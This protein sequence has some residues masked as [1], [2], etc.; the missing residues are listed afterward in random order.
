MLSG[1]IRP[2][3]NLPKYILSLVTKS[4]PTYLV[5]TGPRDYQSILHRLI[6]RPANPIL[7][8]IERCTSAGG[9]RACQNI[10][11]R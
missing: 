4:I 3:L 9:F 6:S 5:I 1:R 11:C 2:A 10:S 7:S 8:R